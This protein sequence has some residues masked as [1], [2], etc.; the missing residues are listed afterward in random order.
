MVTVKGVFLNERSSL[1]AIQASVGN[2]GNLQIN[3]ERLEILDGGEVNA[4]TFGNGWGGTIEVNASETVEVVGIGGI[5]S[6]GEPFPS[7]LVARSAL[8]MFDNPATGNGGDLKIN[9][10]NLFVRDGAVINVATFGGGRGGN[11]IVNA[12]ES[13]QILGISADGETG[14]LLTAVTEGSND[15]GLIQIETGKLILQDGGQLTAG[16]FSDG[17]GGTLTINAS[18]SVEIIGTNQEFRTVINTGSLI[19]EETQEIPTGNAGDVNITTERL[20]ISDGAALAA[21]TF[22]SGE[23]GELVV[24]ANSIELIGT[25]VIIENGEN[26]TI[27][28]A[29]LARTLGSGMLAT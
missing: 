20:S 19:N 23:G 2:G 29:L 5:N 24:N 15:A 12:T 4:S 16:T 1:L 28:S 13:V 3:T 11:L 14:S 9:T 7:A 26:T 10:S 22:G 21:S 6:N 8:D 25:G 27:P 17:N 18:E